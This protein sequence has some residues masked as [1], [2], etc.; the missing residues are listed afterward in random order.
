MA[1]TMPTP[2]SCPDLDRI[3]GWLTAPGRRR[4]A[5]LTAHIYACSPCTELVMAEVR[6][7]RENR[8]RTSLSALAAS[9]VL[10][11]GAWQVGLVFSGPALPPSDPGTRTVASSSPDDL[12]PPL[13][14][15]G[16]VWVPPGWKPTDRDPTP[17]PEEEELD[18]GN[19]S[20]RVVT[21][22][23]HRHGYVGYMFAE[24]GAFWNGDETPP[25][26]ERADLMSDAEFR[27]LV[28]AR[29]GHANYLRVQALERAIRERNPVAIPRAAFWLGGAPIHH[30]TGRRD[31]AAFL[32]K[33]YLGMFSP[34]EVL[35]EIRNYPHSEGRIKETMRE[36]FE[37]EFG[38]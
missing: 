35:R 22:L 27:E 17:Y 1:Q 33:E 13:N 38:Q 24:D 19:R 26:D 32:A 10:A 8:R 12:P 7:R 25:D 36:N 29:R 18:Y 20:A 30:I 9:F 2:S 6:I 15:K 28:L 31:R 16:E 23:K 37:A 21:W 5:A 34:E 11:V 3:H 4:D 14:E